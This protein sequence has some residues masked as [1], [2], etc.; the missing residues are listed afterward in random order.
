MHG[1]TEEQTI[2]ELRKVFE[3]L[4]KMPIEDISYVQG[5]RSLNKYERDTNIQIKDKHNAIAYFPKKCP[6]HISG[7]IAMNALIDW[8]YEL[9][10]MDRINEGDKGMIVFVTP[11]NLFGVKAV[12]ING[13]WN[14]K[15]YEYFKIDI[16]YLMQRLILGPLTPT[17]EAVGFRIFMEDIL[18]FKFVDSNND[19][20][21]TLLF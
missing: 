21:Q 6:Y 19:M 20:I 10:D 1:M 3:I 15:L 11:S 5:V 12:T 4:P 13:R 8:D 7:S 18:Q 17:F 9:N 2:Q 16:E 14:P